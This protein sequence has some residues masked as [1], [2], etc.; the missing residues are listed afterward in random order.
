MR[1]FVI[2]ALL[3]ILLISVGCTC[4]VA[5]DRAYINC[6][7]DVTPCADN[8][9]NLGS[10]TSQWQNLY[11][12]NISPFTLESPLYNDLQIAMANA[13]VPA[14]SAPTWRYFQGVEVPAFSDTQV[15]VLYF[16]AQLTHTYLEGSDLEFHIHVAYPDANAGDIRWY[17]NYSWANVDADFPAPT[18]VMLTASSPT[19]ANRHQLI[20]IAPVIDGTGK[21]ISS[22]LVCSIQRLGNAGEDTYPSEIYLVSGDFHYL[23]DTMGSHQLLVK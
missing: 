5:G 14:A 18:T 7:G 13:K 2:V 19:T 1:S 8:A 6:H 17:F 4:N 3:A 15:N 12:Y 16:T 9:Y 22:V 11:V 23:V 10:P 21:L 20:S